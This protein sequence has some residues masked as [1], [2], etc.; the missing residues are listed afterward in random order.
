MILE[1]SFFKKILNKN[2]FYFF[3]FFL[4]LFISIFHTFQYGFIL[5]D[6]HLVVTFLE[7]PLMFKFQ[8]ASEY[9]KFHFY[10]VYFLTHM[11]DDFLTQSL[12]DISGYLDEKRMII[13]RISNAIFH[14]VNTFILFKLLQ[15]IFNNEKKFMIFFGVLFF[16]MHPIISQPLFNV[17]S[18]NELLYL[19]FS[20]LAFNHSF[21]FIE[22][23]NGIDLLVINI[24]F[25]LALC[26]KLFAIFF[27]LLIPSFF[28]L[29]H[30]SNDD[31]KNKYTTILT[32]FLS[33][34]IT[35]SIYYY[36]RSNLTV[37]YTL[38]FDT[39][40]INNFFS[41]FYFYFRGLFFPFE[42][43]YLVIEHSNENLGKFFFLIATIF[44]FLSIYLFYK[45]KFIHLL[46][47]FFWSGCALALPIYFGLLTERSFP[48][49]SVMAERYSYGAA[50]SIS[51]L[52]IILMTQIPFKNLK[53]TILNLNFVFLLCV[54][55]FILIDRS[56]VYK[57]DYIFWTSGM[58]EHQPH[59]YYNI[60]PAT[61]YANIAYRTQDEND[62]K[63]TL[64]HT[65][66]NFI[67]YPKSITNHR[68]M[69][70]NYANWDK[71]QQ[72]E[73]VLG[74]YEKNF[75]K[76]P[77]ILFK[78]AQALANGKNYKEAKK[79][80]DQIEKINIERKIE[81]IPKMHDFDKGIYYFSKDELYFLQGVVYANLNMKQQAFEY[82]KKAYTYNFLHSTAMY[83]AGVI[84][85]ELGDKDT[86]IKLI[87]NAVK[88]NPKFQDFMN[89]SI[90]N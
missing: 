68:I 56:K 25:F 61:M 82:F 8:A 39:N 17:T 66:Q 12:L 20:L 22:K 60:V 53:K 63:R 16:L 57:N 67:L 43:L 76:H 54:V 15:K 26:S 28:T 86:A 65:H 87:N 11:F 81:A 70:T 41:S 59:L 18:R 29:K 69:I 34:I 48:L 46:F 79:Y 33:F 6:R 84:A 72:T 58:Y 1:N 47:Y 24:Y 74:L 83:N 62:F 21:K 75:G 31:L 10:P 35:F 89:Q 85:K 64:F 5:D 50:P 32:I 13:P 42:H 3:I 44:F 2:S 52:I 9:A 30:Y 90:K 23:N 14:L 19:L 71:P 49:I 80:L 77:G 27:I 45:K 88:I 73:G 38:D 40:I 78:K 4:I 55:V 7:R 51:I 36:L 37:P